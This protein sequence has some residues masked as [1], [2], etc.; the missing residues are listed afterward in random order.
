MAFATIQDALTALQKGNPVIIVDDED[1]ENEGDLIYAAEYI[2][3][4][5]IA[6]MLQHTSGILCVPT[7][8]QRLEELDIPLMVQKNTSRYSC[9]FTI[10]VDAKACHTGVSAADRSLTI[11]KLVSGTATD[12]VQPGHIFPLCAVSGGVLKRVGH[13]EAVVD[14]CTLATLHP[15]GVLGEL[16]LKD[17]TMMRLHGLH[18]F[19]QEHAIPLIQIR[20]II[21]YRHQREQLVV[22]EDAIDMPTLF[23]DFTL[24]PYKD[25]ITS[26]THLA[27]IKGNVTDK[28]SVLVRAHSECLT[29]DVFE[30]K[31]CDCGEQLRAAFETIEKE[32]CGVILYMRQEGRGIGLMNKL[33]AYHLQEKGFDTV[34]ANKL[35]GFKA[36]LRH[37]GIGAQMLKDIG[38]T[39]FRLLTNNPKKIVGLEGYGLEVV[40]RVALQIPSNE[41][42]DAY[43]KAKKER[44]GHLLE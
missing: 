41:K 13:T 2:T 38:V 32:G 22:R 21:A 27:L 36:D 7:T 15:L 17:G 30:S 24:I 23:G 35:L 37:Y 1:R 31:R 9:A 28:E 34:D 20:D 40:E 25:T 14:L 3:P 33:K 16:M 29:G 5:K 43:L 39:R 8:E 44:L 6:F 11:Q 19:S 18:A 12:F 26:V 4:E 42:N 10:S